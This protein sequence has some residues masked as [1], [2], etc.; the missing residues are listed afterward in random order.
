MRLKVID[1][2]N[3]FSNYKVNLEAALV[4]RKVVLFFCNIG[5]HCGLFT[6][7]DFKISGL[8]FERTTAPHREAS[9]Q[10]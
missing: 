3:K 5:E 1:D 9:S 8:Y 2:K 10:V 6:S 7:V 4:S